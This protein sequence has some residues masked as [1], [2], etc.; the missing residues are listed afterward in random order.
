LIH[1]YSETYYTEESL[2]KRSFSQREVDPDHGSAFSLALS[3]VKFMGTLETGT[4]RQ[5][6]EISNATPDEVY[7]AFLSSKEHSQF[8]GSKAKIS[9]KVGDKFETW[10]GYIMGKNVEL[11]P[12]KKIV[13]DWMT[14]E[15]PDGYSFSKL[16]I[17][18]AKSKKSDG[19]TT[20]TIVHTNVPASQVE[21]Y[22]SGWHESYW[23]P[24]NTYFSEKKHRAKK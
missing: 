21:K 1:L 12:G 14:D 4:I 2:E 6:V 24:L 7:R 20:L 22:T 3:H 8:T 11:T 15:F 9:A 13:Q 16:Q 5:K 19:G 17:T 18:L 10:D 23:D